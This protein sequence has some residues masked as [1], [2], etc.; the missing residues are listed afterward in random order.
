MAIGRDM[1]QRRYT[2]R[3]LTKELCV[4]ARTLR[5]YE[6]E[7]MVQ[8]MRL[9]STR[10]YTE[11]DRAHLIIIL[12]GRRLGFSVAEM[13]F[14]SKMYD[15]KDGDPDEMAIAAEKFTSRIRELEVMKLDLDQA[16]RQL[17]GCVAE[18]N[19]ALEGKPR[20]PWERFF[21]TE[22]ALPEQSRQQEVGSIRR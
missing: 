8:P 7:G 3:Q 10:I 9:G 18:I 21:D 12:R 15:F 19:A 17:K 2:I 4:S 6:D 16:L 14:V 5:Y 22:L 13:A 1:G 20:T 11:K